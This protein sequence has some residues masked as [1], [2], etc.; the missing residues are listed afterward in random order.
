MD[1]GLD[2]ASLIFPGRKPDVEVVPAFVR[3]LTVEDLK[4][5]PDGDRGFERSTLK[6]L[7]ERHHALARAVA[8]G[9]KDWEA[10]AVAGYAESTVK[11]LKNDPSFKELVNRYAAER[12]LQFRHVHEQMAALSKDV[13]DSI[14]DDLENDKLS[15][16]Q[17]IEVAKLT[18]DRTGFG[19]QTTSTHNHNF[20]IDV[21]KRA[22]AARKRLE[23]RQMIDITPEAEKDDAA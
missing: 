2:I 17:K 11:I 18:L 4:R 21:A 14:H 19:P 20:T 1:L 13:V 7:T 5:L 9:M 8:S 10:G 6:K 3:A 12:D 16:G 23:E 22:E 15:P